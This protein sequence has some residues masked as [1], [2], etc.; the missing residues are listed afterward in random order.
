MAKNREI[1]HQHSIT[2]QERQLELQ[3]KHYNF[4]RY[5]WEASI[6]MK[7]DLNACSEVACEY[8]INLN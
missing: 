8:L 1:K 7:D 2:V 5:Q 3:E 4:A 6:M